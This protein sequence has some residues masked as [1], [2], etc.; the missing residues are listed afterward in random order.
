MGQNLE[1]V[2]SNI[3]G[4]LDNN[5]VAK[6]IVS[7]LD[8]TTVAGKPLGEQTNFD[9]HFQKRIGDL[10]KVIAFVFEVNYGDFLDELRK[11]AGEA[12]QKLGNQTI[13]TQSPLKSQSQSET[14]G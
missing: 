13:P 2:I 3:G 7:F 11:A 14:I 4:K 9:L 6:F 1:S 12:M 10:F 5:Q 8:Q